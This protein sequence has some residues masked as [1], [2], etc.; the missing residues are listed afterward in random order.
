MRACRPSERLTIFDARLHLKEK[1]PITDTATS[2][3][4]IRHELAEVHS[5]HTQHE[6]IEAEKNP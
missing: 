3:G 5:G 6:Y 2:E 1:R 4:D